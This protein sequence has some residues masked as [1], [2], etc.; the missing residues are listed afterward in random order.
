MVA[1]YRE[2]SELKTVKSEPKIPVDTDAKALPE[3]VQA[4][5]AKVEQI[6]CF[7]FVDGIDPDNQAM[8]YLS[9]LN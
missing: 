5:L 7:K 8:K 6:D 1:V 3:Q 2:L 9:A 4:D